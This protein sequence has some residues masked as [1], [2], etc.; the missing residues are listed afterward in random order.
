T[1]TAVPPN[2][3]AAGQSMIA[4]LA[5]ATVAGMPSALSRAQTMCAS[6]GSRNL[7]TVWSIC[8]RPDVLSA[9]EPDRL[10]S[11]VLWPDHHG[12]GQL[13]VPP[14]LAAI[15][16]HPDHAQEQGQHRDEVGQVAA[17]RLTNADRVAGALIDDP[18]GNGHLPWRRLFVEPEQD[19]CDRR[20]DP[21]DQEIRRSGDEFGRWLRVIAPPVDGN[22]HRPRDHQDDE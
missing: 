20:E 16:R 18:G 22:E 13:V 8:P 19:H 14:L 7:S 10:W 1:C 21:G 15:E 9:L 3:S 2:A 11:A 12:A 17:N 6:Q 5:N 4:W